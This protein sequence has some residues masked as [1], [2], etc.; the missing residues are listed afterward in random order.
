MVWENDMSIR[1]IDSYIDRAIKTVESQGNMDRVIS[2]AL[3]KYL[4]KISEKEN[5]ICRF[6]VMAHHDLE[7]GC[8]SN[9]LN[10][11]AENFKVFQNKADVEHSIRE[12]LRKGI[13]RIE[14]NSMFACNNCIDL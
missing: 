6:I 7:H 2:E 13:V 5:I 12:L 10:T 3:E 8:Y 11:V 9:I 14:S 4:P 1:N